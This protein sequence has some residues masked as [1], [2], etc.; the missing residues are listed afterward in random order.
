[1]RRHWFMTALASAGFVLP[2][3]AVSADS[4]ACT[5]MR[6]VY[7][8]IE[9]VS[10]PLGIRGETRSQ[11][12]DRIYGK[13]VWREGSAGLAVAARVGDS[14]HVALRGQEGV[15]LVRVDVVAEAQLEYL[16]KAGVL[17]NIAGHREIGRYELAGDVRGDLSIPLS[18]LRESGAMLVIVLATRALPAGQEVLVEAW[19]H[20]TPGCER[21]VLVPDRFTAIRLNRDIA[22]QAR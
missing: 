18:V 3:S 7:L 6:A 9:T 15:A 12:L 5:G 2:S 21:H 11:Y 14:V 10:G 20:T 19:P 22:E 4:Q 1:M 8:P 16:T 13:G 17:R